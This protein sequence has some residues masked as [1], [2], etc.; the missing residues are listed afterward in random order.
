VIKMG[1]FGRRVVGFETY[2]KS[3]EVVERSLARK[4]RL[5]RGFKRMGRGV[6]KLA[7]KWAE[8]YE[9]NQKAQ[10]KGKNKG[11]GGFGNPDFLNTK[12]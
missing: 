4:A 11:S 8:N 6:K 3:E 2:G 5:K 10:K 9:K 1:F 7:V 12:F